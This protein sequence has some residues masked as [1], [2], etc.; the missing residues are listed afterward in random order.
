MLDKLISLAKFSNPVLTKSIKIDIAKLEI[1]KKELIQQKRNNKKIVELKS[2]SYQNQLILD[3][4]KKKKEQLGLFAISKKKELELEMEMVD[5]RINAISNKIED[6]KNKSK[7]SNSEI[8][9]EL[10]DTEE[11][12]D[13]LSGEIN[14]IVS[15]SASVSENI[16]EYVFLLEDPDVMSVLM[17]DKNLITPLVSCKKTID[18][19]CT[20][21]ILMFQM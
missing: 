2:E 15:K 7:L 12:I 11:K 21:K 20:K 14:D 9:K 8:E 19:C 6:I 13:K 1:K 17:R 5:S 4:L 16:E 10:K 3:N 18:K